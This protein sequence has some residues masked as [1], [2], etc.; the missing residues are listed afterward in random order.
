MHR[1]NTGLSTTR[2]PSP[3]AASALAGAL[4]LLSPAAPSIAAPSPPCDRGD[5]W[6]RG[7]IRIVIG[8]GGRGAEVRRDGRCC[9]DPFR[10]SHSRSGSSRWYGLDSSAWC[11]LTSGRY[12]RAKHGFLDLI[13]C[14][15]CEPVPRIGYAIAAARLEHF[16]EAERSMRRAVE[17]DVRALDAIC[18]DSALRREIRCVIDQYERLLRRS[19][20]DADVHFMLA[21]FQ[22][23]LGCYEQA[24][25]AIENA[26]RYGDCSASARILERHIESKLCREDRGRGHGRDG[27]YGRR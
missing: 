9:D 20:C 12:L 11:D 17:L 3:L 22:T 15:P 24:Q 19:H 1:P 2:R 18:V 7:S 25:C 13:D 23:L 21:A 26:R 4:A 8:S 14:R 27:H 6:S 16:R 5:S 10:C